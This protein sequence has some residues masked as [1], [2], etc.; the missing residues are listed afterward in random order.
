[1]PGSKITTEWWSTDSVAKNKAAAWE[2]AL[3]S[4]YLN[5][6]LTKPLD[7]SFRAQIRQR[8]FGDIKLIECEC[9]PCSGQ[10]SMRQVDK[11]GDVYVGIQIVTGGRE[12]FKLGDKTTEVGP[13]SLVFWN[14]FEPTKFEVH[15]SG[16]SKITLLMPQSLLESRMQLGLLIRGGVLDSTFGIGAILFSHLRA[17]A[18]EFDKLADEDAM[19]VK[20][21]SVE[22]G[23]AAATRLQQPTPR[24]SKSHL[25]YVQKYILENLQDP[26]LSVQKI[27]DGNGISV[28]Y[29]HTLFAALGCSVSRWIM[30]RRLERCRDALVSRSDARCIVKDVAFQWGFS[31]TAHF[32]RV[33]KKKF[34]FTPLEMW[35]VAHDQGE[36][37][38]QKSA[39]ESAAADL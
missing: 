31:D 35:H 34:G 26:E 11:D 1:M 9:G 2:R 28:R 13:G 36:A 12:R 14:S 4:C 39:V 6:E 22:L 38:C 8:M 17:I 18:A 20:W 29:V 24:A 30:D 16:L 21:A 10:R 27:A 19:G 23:A 37:V 25:R 7:E 3:C 15:Q 33:F 32:S 5:W